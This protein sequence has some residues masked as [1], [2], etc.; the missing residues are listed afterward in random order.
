MNCF[1]YGKKW[2]SLVDL[3]YVRECSYITI[4]KLW[5]NFRVLGSW[6][7]GKEKKRDIYTKEGERWYVHLLRC[8]IIV[9]LCMRL[10]RLFPIVLVC[11]CIALCKH[12]YID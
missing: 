4:S 8:R 5:F 1:Y 10:S 7:E 3:Y 2:L 9:A 12:M 6:R 11:C